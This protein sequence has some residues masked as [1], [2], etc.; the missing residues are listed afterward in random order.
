MQ[1]AAA[2]TQMGVDLITSNCD[3]NQGGVTIKTQRDSDNIHVQTTCSSEPWYNNSTSS[4][5][6]MMY[7]RTVRWSRDA[8]KTRMSTEILTN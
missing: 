5:F 7:T 6:H 3:V 2:T 4:T 1:C 8:F